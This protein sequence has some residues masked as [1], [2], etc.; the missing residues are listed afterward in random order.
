M[1]GIPKVAIMGTET[2]WLKLA[3]T[4][5]QLKEILGSNSVPM[6]KYLQTAANTVRELI[7]NTFQNADAKEFYAKIFTHQENP[8][9]ESGHSETIVSGWIMNFYMKPDEDIDHYPHHMSCLPYADRDD[10]NDV[11]Y[12]F[13]I[14]GLS[15]SYLIDDFM[16][17]EY[18]IVHCQNISPNAKDIH[19]TIAAN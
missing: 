14:A 6:R 2:E 1:C 15:S 13:Y 10:P 5:D 16:Y 17:P 12:Y 8:Q 18:N 11:K 9:C 7:K 19:D 3:N 4:V